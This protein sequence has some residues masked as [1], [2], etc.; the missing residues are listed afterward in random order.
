M[1]AFV[2]TLDVMRNNESVCYIAKLSYITP[3]HI[4]RHT[5]PFAEDALSKMKKKKST[6]TSQPGSGQG[7]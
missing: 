2:G 5:P 7:S 6:R 4:N 1:R 3:T